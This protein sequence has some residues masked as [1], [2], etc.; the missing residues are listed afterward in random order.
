MKISIYTFV[1]DGIKFDFHVVDMLRH[2]LDFADEIIV[3]EGFSSDSTYDRIRNIDPKIKIFR[4]EWDRSDPKTW[5]RKF[6]DQT[7]KLC[8]GD[9]CILLDCDEFIPEWD[10]ENIRSHLAHTDKLI[11]GMHYLN[12]YG[13]YKVI[14]LH[15][16]KNGW[17]AVKHTIHRNINDIEVWGDGSNVRLK[18]CEDEIEQQHYY[19]VPFVNVHHF[20]FVRDAARLR[21]KWRQQQSRNSNNSWGNLVPSF[22]FDLLPHKWSD[23]QF[24]N[25]LDLYD[26]PFIKAV[27]N[28]PQEFIRDNMELYNFIKAKKN[29]PSP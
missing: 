4:N 24:I 19:G 27:L 12:F 9:W 28:N 16:Q 3:N 11:F 2:H 26:G 6:K 13:N 14:N 17:P 15:P 5:S 29:V 25:D 10:F 22:L 21:E 1:K 20:G 8:T 18:N 23:S 7:R